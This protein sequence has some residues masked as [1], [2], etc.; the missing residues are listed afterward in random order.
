MAEERAISLKAE[1]EL[2]P[3]AAVRGEDC[4]PAIEQIY[5]LH[6]KRVARWVA[7]LGG[8][9][10][11]LE[12]LVQ[13]VFA[14]AQQRLPSFRGEARLETWLYGITANVVRHERRR[15]RW[16][17]W[18]GGDWERAAE[19]LPESAPLASEQIESRQ[20][21]QQVN[22]ILD[23]LAESYREVLILFEIEGLPGDQVARLLGIT[24][25]NLWVRLHRARRAF[26]KRSRALDAG[27]KAGRR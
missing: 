6:A 16:R 3:A 4:L 13:E 25:A 27:E 8:A 20:A 5:R 23:G 17:R 19:Q 1:P 21:D 22:A 7:R 14:I 24:P 10:V 9:R 15:Q 18:L 2:F 26:L 12:D 11:E